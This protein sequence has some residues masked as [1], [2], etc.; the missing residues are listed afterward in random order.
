MMTN[1]SSTTDAGLL[2]DAGNT[3]VMTC[4]LGFAGEELSEV[5]ST[6]TPV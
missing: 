6:F 5:M 2:N 3:A 1:R 4:L